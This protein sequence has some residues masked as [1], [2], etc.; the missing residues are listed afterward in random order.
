MAIMEI[1]LP[2]NV[3][4]VEDNN[5]TRKTLAAKVAQNQH[6]NLVGA[7][8]GCRQAIEVLDSDEIDVLLVDLDLPDGDGTE[9]IAHAAAMPRDISIMV[10]SVF[11]DERHVIRAIRAGAMGYLLKDEDGPEIGLA[12][13]QLLQGISPISPNIAHHLISALHPEDRSVEVEFTPREFEV[14]TLAAKGFTYAETAELIGVKAST[15]GSY[16][17][18]IYEKLAVGSRAEA[19]FEASRLGL[20][21]NGK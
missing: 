14:L 7:V 12:I 8:S 18:Q 2:S 9:V 4:L 1:V 6:L 5:V 17:K 10:I 3:L 11:G 16:T 19:I 20:L 21:E 13:T 15:V